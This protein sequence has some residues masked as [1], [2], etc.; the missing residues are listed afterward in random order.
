MPAHS[1]FKYISNATRFN[2]EQLT[3]YVIA[4]AVLLNV[5]STFQVW[6]R[7]RIS[8]ELGLSCDFGPAMIFVGLPLVVLSAGLASVKRH[9]MHSADACA[10]CRDLTEPYGVV[11]S[12]IIVNM[13][14]VTISRRASEVAG[15]FSKCSL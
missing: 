5:N 13:T 1:T 6:T 10:T 11:R 14:M 7:L 4:A 8:C 3:G 15:Y 2:G 9:V 12:F